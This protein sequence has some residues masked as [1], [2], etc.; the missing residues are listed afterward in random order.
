MASAKSLGSLTAGDLVCITYQVI[1]R[2][3]QKD[4]EENTNTNGTLQ[5]R[6]RI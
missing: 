2:Q 6:E 3:D 4:L 1:H 5:I